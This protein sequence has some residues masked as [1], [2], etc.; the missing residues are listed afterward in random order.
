MYGKKQSRYDQ[1]MPRFTGPGL[2]A[3]RY[4]EHWTKILT[5]P[6]M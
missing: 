1:V 3:A 2:N 6:Y 5:E 4:L